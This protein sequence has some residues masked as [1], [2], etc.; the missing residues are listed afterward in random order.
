MALSTWRRT[1]YRRKRNITQT[2]YKKKS[3][4]EDSCNTALDSNTNIQHCK[5]GAEFQSQ[6]PI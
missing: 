6:S 5:L 3:N 1:G 4:K 2:A